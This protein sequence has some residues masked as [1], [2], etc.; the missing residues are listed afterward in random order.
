MSL[1]TMASLWRAWLVVAAGSALLAGAAAGAPLDDSE[2]EQRALSLMREIACLVCDGQ[3]IAESDAPVAVRMRAQVRA[4]VAEGLSDDAVRARM[5]ERYGDA[6]LLRPSAHG[7]GLLLWL[8]PVAL[9]LVGA[10]ASVSVFRG[11]D[12]SAN[13][14]DSGPGGAALS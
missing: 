1:R 3:A 14:A 8:A 12:G 4:A 5:A 10:A 6:A 7:A 2:A 11:G 9:V 13:G